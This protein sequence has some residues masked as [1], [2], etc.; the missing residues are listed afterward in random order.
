MVD[1]SVHLACAP[2]SSEAHGTWRARSSEQR[3]SMP[4]HLLPL[5]PRRPMLGCLRQWCQQPLLQVWASHVAAAAAAGDP[6]VCLHLAAAAAA[7]GPCR[8]LLAWVEAVVEVAPCLLHSSG[9]YV[10]LSHHF[11]VT[12]GGS[13]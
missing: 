12:W 1:S 7:A 11:W 2:L 9:T 13:F 5:F 4:C 6:W 8:C 3:C 10:I